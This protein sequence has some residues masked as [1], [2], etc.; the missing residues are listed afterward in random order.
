[1]AQETALMCHMVGEGGIGRLAAPAGRADDRPHHP[2]LRSRALRSVCDW[3][4][5]LRTAQLGWR[6]QRGV[7]SRHAPVA[8]DIDAA[9]GSAP[10]G[11]GRRVGLGG[12]RLGVHSDPNG[13]I[14]S[15]SGRLGH[16]P[17]PSG[18]RRRPARTT[19][20]RR[21]SREGRRSGGG[22]GIYSITSAYADTRLILREVN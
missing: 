22:D 20:E 11:L 8:R 1:M 6:G 16:E 15:R 17:A 2:G 7:V 18:A 19:P 5:G 13:G 3:S 14:C 10:S 4:C 12:P 21:P 9:P